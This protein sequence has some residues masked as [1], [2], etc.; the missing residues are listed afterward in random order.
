M[1]LLIS[2]SSPFLNSTFLTHTHAI[3]TVQGASYLVFT[4]FMH[5]ARFSTE[6][7]ETFPE[8]LIL[9]Y[10]TIY[11]TSWLSLTTQCYYVHTN[12]SQSNM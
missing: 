12:D 2:L 1:T 4:S 10:L 5:G 11:S 6:T 9:K 8:Q 3:G 7:N